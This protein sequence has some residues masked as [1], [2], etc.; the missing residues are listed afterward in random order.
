MK[1]MSENELDKYISKHDV[2]LTEMDAAVK[3]SGADSEDRQQ[4]HMFEDN[5]AITRLALAIHTEVNKRSMIS[6]AHLS[7]QIQGD[8]IVALQRVHV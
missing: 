8:G 6:Q 4:R 5:L 2:M 7:H 1:I 3:E